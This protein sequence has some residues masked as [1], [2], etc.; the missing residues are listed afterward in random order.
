MRQK[1]RKQEV[2]GIAKEEI[3]KDVDTL[4]IMKRLEAKGDTN[5]LQTMLQNGN[6]FNG[7]FQETSCFD[8]LNELIQIISSLND[9]SLSYFSNI[10]DVQKKRQHQ[11]KN[12]VLIRPK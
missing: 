12:H 2:N 9:M 3:A 1:L 4:K 11:P 10:C 7:K 5:K 6:A 8:I